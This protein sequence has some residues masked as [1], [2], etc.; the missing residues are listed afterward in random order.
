MTSLAGAVITK[1]CAFIFVVYDLCDL[2]DLYD[3]AGEN[4]IGTHCVWALFAAHQ[5]CHR[6]VELYII[7]PIGADSS[8]FSSWPI[9]HSRIVASPFFISS[10][11]VLFNFFTPRKQIKN[12][13]HTP[14]YMWPL[15][16]RYLFLYIYIYFLFFFGSI[17]FGR[18]SAS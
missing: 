7:V 13:K 11:R 3:F 17:V 12:V 16:F 8:L 18:W 15:E 5:Q 2:Y 1:V 10:R 14:K 6:I 4:S 9:T